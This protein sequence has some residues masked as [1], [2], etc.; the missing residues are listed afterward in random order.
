MYARVR[1]LLTPE[2]R[3]RYMTIPPDISE[4]AFGTFFTLSPH[5]IEI[6]N[7][8]RRDH[9]RLG[10]ALQLCVLR[11]SGWTL[12]D[13]KVIPENIINYVAGQIKV[14]PKEYQL[15]SQRGATRYEHLDEICKEYGYQPFTLREYRRKESWSL[16][17]SASWR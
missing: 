16:T 12:S 7:R 10:F 5:D 3:L 9:N 14:N 1:E 17:R 11:Y 6:V 13:I 15:Y 2:E 4:W 8:H